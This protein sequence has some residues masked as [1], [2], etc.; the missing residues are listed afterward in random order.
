MLK[1]RGGTACAQ[2]GLHPPLGNPIR[3]HQLQQGDLLL[4][5]CDFYDSP[6]QEEQ[7]LREEREEEPMFSP[8]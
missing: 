6:P 7:Q 1:H 4:F 2:I 3:Q 5:V 8:R